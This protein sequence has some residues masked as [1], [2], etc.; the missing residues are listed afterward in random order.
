[1]SATVS[2]STT[3]PDKYAAFARMTDLGTTNVITVAAD[4][5]LTA[6]ESG[7]LV[8]LN[9][10]NMVVTLPAPVVGTSFTFITIAT[11]NGSFQ[12]VI[13]DAVTTF[14]NGGVNIAGVATTNQFAA[15]GSTHRSVKLNGT[16]T[17]GII[18][19]FF[20]MTCTSSTMWTITGQPLGSGTGATPFATS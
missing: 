5:T 15:D 3:S 20:T 2:V 10:T 12:K 13:T 14:I 9:A 11:A 18:G 6:N 7:S 17:G 16:T 4:R 8:L 1:M 19:G